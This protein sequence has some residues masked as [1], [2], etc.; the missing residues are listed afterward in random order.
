MEIV[1]LRLN[2]E[3]TAWYKAKSRKLNDQNAFYDK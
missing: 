2:M 1:A 3:A